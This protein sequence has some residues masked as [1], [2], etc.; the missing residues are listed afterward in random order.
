MVTSSTAVSSGL[1]VDR[2]WQAGG[3]RLLRN[4]ILM[5]AG[6]L[7]LTASAKFQVPF[8]PVPMTL[9]TLAVLI[10]GATFGWRLG[11][12]TVIFYLAQ[13]FMGLPVFASP[14]LAGPAYF[15]GPTAGFLVGF[16]AS[17]GIVGLAVEKGAARSLPL[18]TGAML[19]AQCVVFALGFVWLANFATLASG[20]VGLGATK[21]FAFAIQPYLL[22]DLLKTAIAV[23]LVLVLAK[24]T[25][26]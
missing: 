7:L 16:I 4:A 17:A 23:A 25:E 2:L 18:L 10:I 15:M 21:T 5:I 20:A 13:G 11:M 26:A 1:L 14:T 6:S 8:Y 19:L 12:A 3:H 22:G 9:Q 24:K